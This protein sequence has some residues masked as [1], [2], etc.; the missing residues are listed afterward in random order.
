MAWFLIGLVIG[1][2]I[3]IG[4]FFI[5]KHKKNKKQ[6]INDIKNENDERKE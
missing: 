1:I 3:Y 5:M 2:V 4:I 6:C